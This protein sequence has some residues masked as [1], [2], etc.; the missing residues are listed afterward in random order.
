VGHLPVGEA[1]RLDA[2]GAVRLLADEVACLLRR[3]AV[4]AR[5]P[6]SLLR[7]DAEKRRAKQLERRGISS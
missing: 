2:G 1:Q 7:S 5:R 4:M 6:L 3:C